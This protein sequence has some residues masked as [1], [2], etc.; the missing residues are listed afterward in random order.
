MKRSDSLDLSIRESK[1]RLNALAGQET[2]TDAEQSECSTLEG[3]V[4]AKEVQ[5]RAAMISEDSETRTAEELPAEGREVR[6]LIEKVELRDYL[7]EAASGKDCVGVAHELRGAIFGDDAATGMVP[8]ESLL[9]RQQ[10]EKR[11][12]AATVGPT[13]VGVTQEQH[14]G[15][16]F[17]AIRY[18]VPGGG[19][20]VSPGR[21]TRLP[22]F[23]EWGYRFATGGECGQ[24]RGSGGVFCFCSF[25]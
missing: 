23:I 7:S 12:D 4:K 15:P 5:Y 11:V 19:F 25:A 2:L 21:R 22:R 3:S 9:P 16:R 13:D 10:V 14:P 20:G 18:R 8:W 6:K 1:T 17:R 24:R